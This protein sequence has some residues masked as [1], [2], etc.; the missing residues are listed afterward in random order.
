MSGFDVIVVGAG[1]NGLVAAGYLATAGVRVLVVEKRDIVGGACVTEEPWPGFRVNTFA[2]VCGLLRPQIVE[3]LQLRKFGYDP[4][5][6]D[7]Q[8]FVPFPDGRSITLW[9]DET[10]NVAEIAKFSKRDAAAYPKYAQFWH[11]ILELIE[12]TLMAPPVALV[13]LFGM[14][15]GP[16]PERL[17]RDLFL[18]SARDFL[19]EWFE[20]E[21][22]KA[23][24]TTQT[25]IGTFAAPSTPGTA[26]VLGHHSIGVLDGH[27]EIWAYSRGGMG[28][29]T[30][31]MARSAEHHGAVVRTGTG[32]RRILVERGRAVGVETDA[33]ETIRSKIVASNLDPKL[34][35][36]KLV[37]PDAVPPEFLA[38]V[39]RIRMRGAALKFNAALDALPDFTARPGA[40]GT[41]HRGTIEIIPSVDYVER[42]YDEAK[43]GAFSS[44]PFIESQFQSVVDPSVAPPGKHT[45]TSFVQYAPT[46]LKGTD[47]DAFK[48]QAAEI[49]LRTL[50][51]YAPNIRRAVSHWQIVSPKD[52]ER[53]I[54]LTGGNIFQ[55]DIT[56][57]QI[58]SFRPL[59]GWAT[60]RMPVKGLYLCGAATHPGGGVI[61]AAGHNAAQVI[62]EDLH[63]RG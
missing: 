40:P 37:P 48:P 45:M 24:F 23:A 31:A 27:K 5:L 38:G 3:D 54:G 36:L 29:V 52:M 43:Y 46:G 49:I 58:F 59:P 41:H 14:F 50:E 30:E 26:Y 55:G 51:A 21:E 2:Y 39:R 18:K 6:Y 17:L 47:W 60:Y 16:E 13:D 34:T 4:I 22:V 20:S 61:G 1:H 9:L 11:E 28:R 7:P 12:P 10:R 8:F 56:P 35:F 63:H 62:L 19:D 57:D 33:G 44:E 32:V 25:I 53:T 42:A 15:S